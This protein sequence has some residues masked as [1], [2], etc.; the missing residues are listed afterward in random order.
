MRSERRA[1]KNFL[2]ISNKHSGEADSPGLWST[3][4]SAGTWG[5][6]PHP[7]LRVMALAHM[8]SCLGFS[9]YGCDHRDTEPRGRGRSG[10]GWAPA[11]KLGMRFKAEGWEGRAACFRGGRALWKVGWSCP[12][13][14]DRIHT[15]D[16]PKDPLIK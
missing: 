14:L 9:R 4:R 16:P 13:V 11:P 12:G 1:G 5:S 8:G 10:G 6:E 2:C 15:Q 3:L 7:R